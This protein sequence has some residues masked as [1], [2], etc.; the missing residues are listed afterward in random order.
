MVSWKIKRESESHD[1]WWC[2]N[3]ER[4]RYWKWGCCLNDNLQL[5]MNNSMN[6]SLEFTFVEKTWKIKS[7]FVCSKGRGKKSGK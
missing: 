6:D 7:K 5:G 3:G 4:G 2:S 1:I